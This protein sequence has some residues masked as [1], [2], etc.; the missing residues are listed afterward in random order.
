MLPHQREQ[1][2]ELYTDAEQIGNAA[3]YPIDRDSNIV[4]REINVREKPARRD[5][6]GERDP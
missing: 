3:K 6:I 2:L 5:T 1:A 4:A